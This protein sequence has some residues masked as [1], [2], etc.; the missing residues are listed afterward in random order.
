MRGERRIGENKEFRQEEKHK[1]HKINDKTQDPRL[2][3]LH[4]VFI[5]II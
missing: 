4:L 1:E 2:V 3:Q 5:I